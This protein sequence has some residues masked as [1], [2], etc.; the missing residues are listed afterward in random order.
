MKR[1]DNFILYI[2]IYKLQDLQLM[3]DKIK[4]LI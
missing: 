3:I 1:N 4:L 2:D